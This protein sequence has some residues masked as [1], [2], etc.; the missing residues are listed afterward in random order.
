MAGSADPETGNPYSSNKRWVICFTNAIEEDEA[1]NVTL[2]S[3]VDIFV[4]Y[5]VNIVL[6]C[7]DL[8]QEEV[9]LGQHFVNQMRAPNDDG[10]PQCD[11]HMLLDPEPT[12]VEKLLEMRLANYK[13]QSNSPL[14]IETFT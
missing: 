9:R 8:T 13:I 12:E 3:V 11:A 1:S 2:D 5:Q 4:K 10:I 14:I 7:Y 6:V